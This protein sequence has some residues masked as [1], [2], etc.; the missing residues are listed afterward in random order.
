MYRNL[1]VPYSV[2]P[3]LIASLTLGSCPDHSLSG[4]SVFEFTHLILTLRQQFARD[5]AGRF[6]TKSTQRPWASWGAQKG[7]CLYTKPM[8]SAALFGPLCDPSLRL[9]IRAYAAL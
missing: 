3:L 4:D 8:H 6:R 7:L 2:T 5:R 1:F 9:R